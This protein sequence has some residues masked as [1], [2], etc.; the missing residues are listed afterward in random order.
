ML[1]SPIIAAIVWAVLLGAAGGLLTDIGSWYRDLKKPSWQPPDWLFGPAWTIILGLAAWAAILS[2]DQANSESEQ[3]TL[4]AVYATNFLFHL[5]WSPLFFKYQ[6]PDWALVEVIF[7]WLSVV[8]MLYVTW[9][10]D[11]LA[12]AMILP[13]FLWVSFASVLNAKIVQLNRPFG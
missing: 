2:W 1:D 8:A 7:L 6:R 11:P 3:A 4:I 5:L 10:F 9:N 12:G 13:Y